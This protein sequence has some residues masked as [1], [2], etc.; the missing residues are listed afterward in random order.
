MGYMGLDLVAQEIVLRPML[1]D[2]S[3]IEVANIMDCFGP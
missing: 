1:Y 2:D 3:D